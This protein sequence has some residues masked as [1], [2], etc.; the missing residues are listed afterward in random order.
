MA[1]DTLRPRLLKFSSTALLTPAGGSEPGLGGNP[2]L[3]A[4]LGTHFQA[5]AREG[6]PTIPAC[7]AQPSQ[8]RP[9]SGRHVCAS[10]GRGNRQA[11]APK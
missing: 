4:G 11:V 7:A 1:L 8:R 6:P 3:P 2:S 5:G 10:Y 9:Q